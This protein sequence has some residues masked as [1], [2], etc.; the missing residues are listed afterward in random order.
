MD[1]PAMVSAWKAI[2]PRDK[3]ST[4]HL[5][6]NEVN[7]SDMAELMWIYWGENSIEA[8]DDPAKALNPHWKWWQFYKPK[9]TIRVLLKTKQGREDVWKILSDAGAWM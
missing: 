9:N 8:L 5:L 1:Y 7:D 6:L 2:R 3:T 4:F